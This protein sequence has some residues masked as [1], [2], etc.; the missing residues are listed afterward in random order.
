MVLIKAPVEKVFA[1][2]LDP[3]NQ[4]EWQPTEM[5]LVELKERRRLPNGGWY[6]H[7]LWRQGRKVFAMVYQDVEVVP[8][9]L[10]ASQAT[11]PGRDGIARIRFEPLSGATL[12]TLEVEPTGRWTRR[13]RSAVV[14][15]PVQRLLARALERASAAL[16]GR[17]LPR[18]R[19]RVPLELFLVLGGVALPVLLLNQALGA[20]GVGPLAGN[21]W[22]DVALGLVLPILFIVLAEISAAGLLRRLE[23]RPES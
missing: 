6:Q 2:F 13:F 3:D 5:P 18:K 12:V 15:L 11:A 4:G 20:M 1:Y 21:R 7:G 19:A 10:I 8:N 22:S 16:E 14:M 17:P 23:R 9:R